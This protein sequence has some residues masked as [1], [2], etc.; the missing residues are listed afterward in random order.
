[1]EAPVRAEIAESVLTNGL[2]GKHDNL[3]FIFNKAWHGKEWTKVEIK[4]KLESR[5]YL[6]RLKAG[7][8]IAMDVFHPFAQFLFMR[9]LTTHP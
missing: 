1:M 9:L 2:K 4:E 6:P 8:R 7:H 5:Y 3:T